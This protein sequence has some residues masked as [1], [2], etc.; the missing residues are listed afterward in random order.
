MNSL[1]DGQQV[2]V[3]N[4]DYTYLNTVS[5]KR[6]MT[7]LS[8]ERVIVEKYAD[9]LIRTFEKVM[10]APLVVRFVYFIRRT[11]RKQVEWGKR[12][13]LIRDGYVCQ[14]CGITQSDSGRK[15]T[16]DHVH[17]AS[18]GGKSTFENTVA[19]CFKCNN[20][21]EDKSCQEANMYPKCKL[22]QPTVTEFLQKMNKLK[23]I[24]EIMAEFWKAF[25]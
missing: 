22:V 2:L 24:D 12:N 15:L 23:G 10:N 14:Y 9:T 4:A 1:I 11:Y 6:A 18:K 3:L 16:I 20:R 21:K 17:P 19:A 7:Y 5:V 8:K 13:V 25:D